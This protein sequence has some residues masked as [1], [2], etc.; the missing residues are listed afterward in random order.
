M[1][2]TTFQLFFCFQK[3]IYLKQSLCVL[4]IFAEQKREKPYFKKYLCMCGRGPTCLSLSRC[5]FVASG[6]KNF[7]SLHSLVNLFIFQHK[8]AHVVRVCTYSA[9]FRT[10]FNI[11]EELFSLQLSSASSLGILPI[12]LNKFVTINCL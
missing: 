9:V 1:L 7:F 4:H 3:D 6:W 11:P 2:L 8:S 5:C 10:G 12:R